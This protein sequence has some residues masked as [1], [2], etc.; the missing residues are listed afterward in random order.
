VGLSGAVGFGGYDD[1]TESLSTIDPS[2]VVNPRGTFLMAGA[3][4]YGYGVASIR[5]DGE[6][7]WKRAGDTRSDGTELYTY[8]SR[9]SA[10]LSVAIKLGIDHNRFV[11][12]PAFGYAW[13][14][15]HLELLVDGA[16]EVRVS[17]YDR[18]KFYG[19]R[20]RIDPYRGIGLAYRW[21][22]TDYAPL[23][24]RSEF[25]FEISTDRFAKSDPSILGQ[26]RGAI[27]LGYMFG[28][29]GDG[30]RLSIGLLRLSLWG[31]I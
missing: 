29:R 27:G 6:N 14:R 13:T 21:S 4:E 28:E 12:E 5:C 9:R 2:I 25:T 26:I 31:V 24:R 16:A 23:E 8:G 18:G 7:I 15:E 30:R 22:Y 10:V 20:T 19:F 1:L 11:A 3:A 17:Q